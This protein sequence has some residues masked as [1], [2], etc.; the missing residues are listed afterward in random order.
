M[1]VI[2]RGECHA[3]SRIKGIHLL[4]IAGGIVQRRAIGVAGQQLQPSAGMPQVELQRI[5]A[6][7][8]YRDEVAIGLKI[9]PEDREASTQDRLTRGVGE[10]TAF[11][12]WSTGRTG[13]PHLVCLAKTETETRITRIGL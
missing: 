11:Q 2:E 7:L 1:S 3:G 4:S 8:S 10:N 9:N 13:R 6:G 5:V 12:T